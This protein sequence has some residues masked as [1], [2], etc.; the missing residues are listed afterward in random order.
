MIKVLYVVSTLK[1]CGPTNQLSYIIKYL[2]KT[3]FF[4]IVLTLSPE[5]NVE[6]MKSYFEDDL[7][8]KVCTLGLSRAKGLF[9]AS[10]AL[11]KFIK[12]NAIDLIH[13][14]GIRAD[15][16][17]SKVKIKTV[18]TLRNYPYLDYPMTYGKLRGLLM[19]KMHLNCLNKINS[20]VVV[21]KS[22]S[23]MLLN[24]KNYEI[25]YVQ[26]GVDLERFPI[27]CKLDLRKK[28]NIKSNAKVFISVGHLSS[29]KDPLSII[30]AFQSANIENSNL[31]F[32]GDGDLADDC[33]NLIDDDRV[34][35]VGKI[36]NVTDYLMA[37]DYFVSASL[38]E[39]LPNTVLEAMAAKL[40]CIL[41]NIPP[42]LEIAELGVISPLIFKTQDI[43]DLTEK[44][45]A[46]IEN[47][48][49]AMS[50]S[51]RRIIEEYLNA[52][53]MSERYQEKYLALIKNTK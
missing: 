45:H 42:H 16:L 41:S 25:D 51:S 10:S 2:D 19:A 47:N 5:P 52:K 12:I 7:G 11:N 49:E 17:A 31:L 22:V 28:L 1:R 37:S 32:L 48:Y 44:M 50:V 46:I 15:G 13:S 8:I 36:S 33:N 20:P 35:L 24:N 14:Q 53:S 27:A 30:T 6:S 34:I 18:A 39:G 43:D 29:R 26:N 3:K 21:S 38:A 40:P 9:F 23:R 4:P